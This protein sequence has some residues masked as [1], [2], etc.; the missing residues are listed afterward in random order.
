M[1]TL[2][3]TDNAMEFYYP[4]NEE[5]PNGTQIT[6]GSEYAR[7]PYPNILDEEA[8]YV[9][10][11]PH[12]ASVYAKDAVVRYGGTPHIYVVKPIGKI[13]R[14]SL[15]ARSFVGFEIIRNIEEEPTNG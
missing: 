13:E 1:E 6:P 2:Y 11:S 14:V 10:M 15:D 12:I 7:S 8:V 4:I 9:T 3:T 5:I